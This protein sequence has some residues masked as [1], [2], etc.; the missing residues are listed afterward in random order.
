[1][2]ETSRPARRAYQVDEFCAAVRISRA[3]LYKLMKAGRIKTV[4]I[5]GRRLIPVDEAER[6]LREGA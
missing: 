3:S 2:D 1:M 4:T 6:M 5:G